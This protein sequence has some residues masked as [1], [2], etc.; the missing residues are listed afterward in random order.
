ML[1]NQFPFMEHFNTLEPGNYGLKLRLHNKRKETVK[2]FDGSAL[3]LVLWWLHLKGCNKTEVF[4]V[5]AAS[6]SP[7]VALGWVIL[8]SL[9]AL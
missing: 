2:F 3:C 1:A 4:G 9:P 8:P 7:E 6:L 5:A